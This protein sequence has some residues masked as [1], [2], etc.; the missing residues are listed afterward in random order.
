LEFF[1]VDGGDEEEAQAESA[2]AISVAVRKLG[3]ARGLVAGEH[4]M[5]ETI[6]ISHGRPLIKTY[7]VVSAI[8]A[9]SVTLLVVVTGEPPVPA[10]PSMIAATMRATGRLLRIAL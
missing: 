6:Q 5:S 7:L 1:V 2:A 9:A 4:P 3:Y 8:I 10:D